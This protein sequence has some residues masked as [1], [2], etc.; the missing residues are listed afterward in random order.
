[1]NI[2]FLT[3]SLIMVTF[4][5]CSK[6]SPKNP[7]EEQF[8]ATRTKMQ[9]ELIATTRIGGDKVEIWKEPGD[10]H[11]DRFFM[12]A[13]DTKG[14]FL[15][16]CEGTIRSSSKPY[17]Q[18]DRYVALVAASADRADMF[19][20][21]AYDVAKKMFLIRP[22]DCSNSCGVH[23]IIVAGDRVF[24]SS[25][26]TIHPVCA[27]DLRTGKQTR[28]GCPAPQAAEFYF[29]NDTVLV[30]GEDNRVYAISKDRMVPQPEGAVDLK[31][32]TKMDFK[33][34]K[35]AVASGTH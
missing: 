34:L 15:D 11:F 9:C 13:W 7:K 3:T 6:D 16:Y 23:D 19:V 31:K 21:F 30:V 2:R 25:C 12:A 14:K 28:F 24:W 35:I 10:E 17:F 26:K 22:L 33:T 1:M 8:K 5:G 4:T 27:L 32:P 20:C 18:S 29:Y